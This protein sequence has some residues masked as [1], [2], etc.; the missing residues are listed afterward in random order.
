MI[1]VRPTISRIFGAIWLS[2]FAV[3]Q[4]ATASLTDYAY[5]AP[6][7]PLAVE[8]EQ[9][10]AVPL[11]THA[12]NHTAPQFQDLR[13]FTADG[14]EVSYFL[15]RRAETRMRTEHRFQ[16][17]QIR[18][19]QLLSDE[20]MA[21]V[22]ALPNGVKAAT[23]V[24]ISTSLK[25]YQKTV[26]LFSRDRDADAWTELTT[27]A[28]IFDYSRFAD[29][30]QNTI[31]FPPTAHRYLKIVVA[32]IVD[33]QES[34]LMQLSRQYSG[35][36][37]LGHE[38]FLQLQRRPFKIDAIAVAEDVQT[39]QT[40]KLVTQPYPIEQYRIEHLESPAR[41]QLTI[42]AQRQPLVRFKLDIGDTNFHRAV[43]LSA[44]AQ[45]R[46]SAVS[47]ANDEIYRLSYCQFRK[48]KVAV[49]F[50]EQRRQRYSLTIANRDSQPLQ[51][52]AITAEGHVYQVVFLAQPATSYWLYYGN[53]QARTPLYD[54]SAFEALL[55]R[56]FEP[57]TVDLGDAV[58]NPQFAA[59]A[60]RF[61][62]QPALLV[63]AVVIM[64]L[65][66]LWALCAAARKTDALLESSE[67]A[68]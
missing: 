46:A 47:L 5:S 22:V 63:G 7:L 68:P 58:A 12:Y 28:V 23:A 55:Q 21:A 37:L 51:I 2:G 57:L 19:L 67:S 33:V 50:A 1:K 39:Q 52:D 48:Q 13:V 41:T 18:E 25:D 10:V 59:P 44:P 62:S 14:I 43:E 53:D 65:G 45:A 20:R 40:T 34:P 35:D 31:V 26:D 64:I 15:M 61:L 29:V 32:E 49:D 30:R 4:A 3:G 60:K 6:L 17:A 56:G 38:Q 24:R 16:T 27:A 42:A 8:Q 54:V 36:N 66:L 11:T 9:L